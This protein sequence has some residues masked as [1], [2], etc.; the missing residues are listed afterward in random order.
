MQ[1]EPASAL[2]PASHSPRLNPRPQY[3]SQI[4]SNIS[5]AKTPVA[6]YLDSSPMAKVKPDAVGVHNLQSDNMSFSTAPS[7]TG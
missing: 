4:P 3:Y 1:N 7:T 6:S 2:L 5:I